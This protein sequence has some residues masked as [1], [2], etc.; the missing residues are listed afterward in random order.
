MQSD[1]NGVPATAS[2]ESVRDDEFWANRF[3]WCALEAGFRAKAQGRLHE[4][5]YVRRLAYGL[6]ESGAY[7][8]SLAR[9]DAVCQ[10][11]ARAR[12]GRPESYPD[13]ED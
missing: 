5:E 7:R 11:A 8:E 12:L 9:T 1:V 3:H 13:G 2:P 6:Y 4:S 10:S